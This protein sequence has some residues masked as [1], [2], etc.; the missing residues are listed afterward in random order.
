MVTRRLRDARSIDFNFQIVAGFLHFFV[1]GR[2]KVVTISFFVSY[3]DLTEQ[4]P[5]TDNLVLSC[6]YA[7]RS[8]SAVPR[9]LLA[10][11]SLGLFPVM[12]TLGPRGNLA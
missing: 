12:H 10:P 1:M 11:A 4:G 3:D 7:D 6:Y 2:D 9:L 8:S 5:L